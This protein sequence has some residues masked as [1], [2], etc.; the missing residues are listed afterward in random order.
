[1][2]ADI[3]GLTVV[4]VEIPET[5]DEVPMLTLVTPETEN[6]PARSFCIAGLQGII[7]LRNAIDEEIARLGE[8]IALRDEDIGQ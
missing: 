7:A 6:E 8:R 3:D 4:R 1:M 5:E 2:I